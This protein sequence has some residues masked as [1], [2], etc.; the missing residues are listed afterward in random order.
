MIRA[1]VYSFKASLLPAA[2]ALRNIIYF[3]LEQNTTGKRSLIFHEHTERREVISTS[4]VKGKERCVL[5]T[6]MVHTTWFFM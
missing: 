6:L 1:N 2:K 4:I 5:C 3:K